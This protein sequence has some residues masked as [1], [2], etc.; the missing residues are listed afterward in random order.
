[1]D[2]EEMELNTALHFLCPNNV[3]QPCEIA[4]VIHLLNNTMLMK[5]A[6]S[7]FV[8]SSKADRKLNN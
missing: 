5:F 3:Y 1:M 7:S 4:Q 2:K 6:S 8:L